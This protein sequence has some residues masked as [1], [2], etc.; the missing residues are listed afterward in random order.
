MQRV[1]T[2]SRLYEIHLHSEITEVTIMRSNGFQC[3]ACDQCRSHITHDMQFYLSCKLQGGGVLSYD[4]C[5]IGD[6]G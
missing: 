6:E 1:F 3:L 5:P 2:C 4:K